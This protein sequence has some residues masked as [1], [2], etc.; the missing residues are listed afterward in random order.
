[1]AWL[2]T[3]TNMEVLVSFPFFCS[4]LHVVDDTK[5]MQVIYNIITGVGL[6]QAHP[7]NLFNYLIALEV[8][9]CPGKS[10]NF[11]MRFMTCMINI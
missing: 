11:T 2:I 1:M 3:Q 6:P 8:K 4:C 5:I 9:C 7:N 10:S